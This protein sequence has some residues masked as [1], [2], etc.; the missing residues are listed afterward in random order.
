MSS[1][2]LYIMQDEPG[3]GDGMLNCTRILKGQP[4]LR[5]LQQAWPSSH[6]GVYHFR[7][8]I[9][10]EE[11]GYVWKDITNPEDTLPFSDGCIYAKVLRLDR[12]Q[13]PRSRLKMKQNAKVVEVASKA[14]SFLSSAAGVLG[15]GGGG[16][17]GSRTVAQTQDPASYGTQG[18]GERFRDSPASMRSD[19]GKPGTAAGRDT[20]NNNNNHQQQQ[21]QQQQPPPDGPQVRDRVQLHGLRAKPELNGCLGTVRCFDGDSGRYTIDVDGTAVSMNIKLANLRLPPPGSPNTPMSPPASLHSNLRRP[22]L[23]GGHAPSPPVHRPTVEGP[24]A[25][26]A[27]AEH[28]DLF[29][30]FASSGGGGGEEAAS[31]TGQGLAAKRKERM[32]KLRAKQAKNGAL[33]WDPVEERWREKKGKEAAVNIESGKGPVGVKIGR[34]VDD[35]TLSREALK[36]QQQRYDDLKAKQAAAVAEIEARKQMENAEQNEEIALAARLDP[37]LK[38]W[39]EDYGKK[40]NIR[41]LLAGMHEPLWEGAK[42]KAVGMADLLDEKA[43]TKYYRKASIVVHPDRTTKL[44]HEKRF[45]AKRIFDALAQAKAEFDKNGV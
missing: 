20:K 23:G 28:V 11:C 37:V 14:S 21:Q 16:G 8:R 19:S 15:F 2:C 32:E 42:W 36:G 6:G 29:P 7:F 22:T 31:T 5:D 44:D 45:I 13:R 24:T 4:C 17:S 12:P 25:A 35:G 9:S 30:A 27:A 39:S 26:A 10:D 43:V 33:E 38:K 3:E 34:P 18:N 1:V 40:K 41:A